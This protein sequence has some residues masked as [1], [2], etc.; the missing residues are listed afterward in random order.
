MRSRDRFANCS[1][2][3]DAD[4]ADPHVLCYIVKSISTGAAQLARTVTVNFVQIELAPGGYTVEPGSMPAVENGE[5]ASSMI[6]YP[7]PVGE[8]VALVGHYRY[9]AIVAI[10]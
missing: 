10:L 3:T 5:Y 6:G 2:K 7:P 1:Q 4:D 9:S 8:E